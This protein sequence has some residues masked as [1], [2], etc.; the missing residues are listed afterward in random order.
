M[1]PG[2]MSAI[3]GRRTGRM[4]DV[5]GKLGL[6]T[7]LKLCLDAGD[8]ASVA[9]ATPDKW[10]DVSGNGT[11]FFRGSGT[12]SDS[13]DPTF[14]GTPGGQSFQ[15]WS[16]DGGDYFTYDTTAETWMGNC[17]KDGALFS[18]AM[19]VNLANDY[20]AQVF[21][22]TAAST[23]ET[24]FRFGAESLAG[25]VGLLTF[26]TFNGSGSIAFQRGVQP[27]PALPGAGWSFVSIAVDEAGSVMRWNVNGTAASGSC[28]Y[29]APSS[30]S[31]TSTMT[32]GALPGGSSAMR[33]TSRIGT[34]SMWEGRA[35]AA[36][37]LAALYGA[38][39]RRYLG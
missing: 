25:P 4:I 18:L 14:N 32:I 17:H 39:R 16:F 28:T 37:E 13:A 2:M 7:N 8:I 19:W 27:S 35:L 34:L 1:L 31:P 29:S 9:S 36:A 20:T 26:Y 15:Y 12:G 5:L 30:S 22:S 11:D 6:T 24:G 38:S 3:A 21:V 23:S 33:S 10:L